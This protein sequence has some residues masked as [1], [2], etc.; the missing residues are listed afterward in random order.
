MIHPHARPLNATE[1]EA[2]IADHRARIQRMEARLPALDEAIVAA[3]TL[4]GE[5]EARLQQQSAEVTTAR[6][7]AG[8]PISF[9][10]DYTQRTVTWTDGRGGTVQLSGPRPIDSPEGKADHARR[11]Y[12]ALEAEAQPIRAALLD[13]ER[14]RADV[15]KAIGLTRGEVDELERRL[16]QLRDDEAERA[17]LVGPLGF[18]TRLSAI[19]RK[20]SGPTDTLVL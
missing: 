9:G 16:G 19:L 8:Q 20:L 12:G 10:P 18:Q 5:A 2:A 13:L 1:M 3:R 14:E 11:V 4:L 17:R 7:A 15:A 6:L